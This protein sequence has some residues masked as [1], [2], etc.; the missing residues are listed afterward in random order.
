MSWIENLA[1]SAVKI[2]PLGQTAGQQV[3]FELGAQVPAIVMSA[4]RVDDDEIGA[5]SM[6]LAAMVLK[7]TGPSGMLNRPTS[8]PFR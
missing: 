3:I 4:G 1:L 7:L 5:S 2:V 6:A 8:L